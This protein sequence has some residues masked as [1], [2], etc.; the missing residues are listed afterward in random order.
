MGGT[1]V[2]TFE[3]PRPA[4]AYLLDAA[5][6]DGV[7]AKQEASQASRDGREDERRA[8]HHGNSS[9]SE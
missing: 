3:N 4:R 2:F 9:S 6:H 8:A 5:D 1:L 7:E